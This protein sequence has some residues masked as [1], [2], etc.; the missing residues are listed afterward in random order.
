[1]KRQIIFAVVLILATLSFAGLTDK[2]R[3]I[4][5]AG[6]GKS[7]CKA[8]SQAVE[9]VDSCAPN[10]LCVPIERGDDGV[11]MKPDT[12]IIYAGLK[13]GDCPDLES[14]KKYADDIS[15][16]ANKFRR[17][18]VVHIAVFAACTNDTTMVSLLREG[19][20]EAKVAFVESNGI[21]SG[22]HAACAERV[23]STLGTGR[24]IHRSCLRVRDPYI[25]PDHKAGLYRLYETY[26]WFGGAGVFMRK[27]TDLENWSEKKLVTAIPAE[28]D[29][30]IKAWWAPEMHE[31]DEK[32]YLL[33][34]LWRPKCNPVRGTWVFI[35]DSPDGPF[36]PVSD[37]AFTPK[38]E[39]CLDG[40]LWAEGGALY[41][42]FARNWEREGGGSIALMPIKPDFSGLNG[43][44]KHLFKATDYTP[45][46]VSDSN[47]PYID[48]VSEGPFM[49]RSQ[50]TGKLH[51]LWSNLLPTGYAV[52]T[53]DSVSGK[54]EGPWAN[55]RILYGKDAGHGMVFRRLD[56]ALSFA[57]HY[58]NSMYSE[59]MAIL[60][61]EDSDFGLKLNSRQRGE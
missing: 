44:Y 53:S 49:F 41:M 13:N 25:V 57:L 60:D 8:V 6:A 31:Y 38:G 2:P 37:N 26:P 17:V 56:G 51:L 16:L 1:M 35:S 50:S 7:F 14:K 40:T 23:L 39:D 12:V 48:H 27:S 43:E 45:T 15:A 11:K 34:T 32:Y 20:L 18:G 30:T 4:V 46:P 54:I 3:K 36:V 22:N 47:R 28:L 21:D 9:K 29:E 59:R 52:M 58:P 42:V 5:V 10:I 24:M 55:H 33:V 19:A 61:L